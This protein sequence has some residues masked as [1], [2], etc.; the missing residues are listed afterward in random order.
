MSSLKG[1]KVLITGGGDG[2]GLM[3]VAKLLEESINNIIIWDLNPEKLASASEKLQNPSAKI[4]AQQVDVSNTEQVIKMGRRLLADIG[5]VD[6]LINNAGIII[7]GPF[8][9]ITP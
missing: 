8:S 1:K 7:G 3:T 9:E 2:I 5:A 6:I 4:I